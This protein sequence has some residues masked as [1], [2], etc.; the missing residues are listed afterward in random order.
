MQMTIIG[1]IITIVVLAITHVI[2]FGFGS[3]W[4]QGDK[5]GFEA[6]FTF[7]VLIAIILIG[8][9]VA[10]YITTLTGAN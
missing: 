2:A 3:S 1:Y 8:G 7:I 5:G 6:W 10:I 4:E 9:G